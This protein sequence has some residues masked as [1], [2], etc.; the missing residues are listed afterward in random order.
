MEQAFR[1]N[2]ESHLY[3]LLL[4]P[5]LM[6]LLVISRLDMVRRFKQWGDWSMTKKLM[7]EASAFRNYLKGSLVLLAIAAMI[8]AW[9]RPQFGSK[10]TDVQR[11]G[12][13]LVI[14]LDV[15]NS[16]MAE[17]ILPNRLENAKLAISKMLDR[18]ENDKIGLIVFA[19]DAYI[20]LPLTTDFTAAKL[21]L[22]AINTQIVPRQGTSI[23][24]AIDLGLRSFSPD[25]E[26]SR[27]MVIITDGENHEEDAVEA[28][29]MAEEKGVAI[30]TIGMGSPQGA[31]IPILNAQHQSDFR[32]D[33]EG[34]VIVTKLNEDLLRQISAQTGGIYVRAT[35]SRTGLNTILDEMDKLEK[36]LI[37][38]QVYAEYDEQFPYFIVLALFFLLAEM[39]LM[40]RK[41]RILAGLLEGEPKK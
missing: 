29:K 26:S 35:S 18:L 41:N 7:P 10:L 27:A 40:A 14:A 36:R 24:S 22:S 9:A 8:I 15:S 38:G 17:D 1:F 33:H 30:H 4:I 20:Q 3:L 39:L 5:A 6:L 16:M 13:E 23:K 21:F 19:G 2:D 37:K 34:V 11:K 12:I 32:T 31:P 25:T 28:A